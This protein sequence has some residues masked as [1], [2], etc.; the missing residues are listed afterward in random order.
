MTDDQDITYIRG[1]DLSIPCTVTLDDSRT[2]DGDETW[3][4]QLKRDVES[5]TLLSKTDSAGITVDGST[6]QP[7]IVIANSDFTTLQFPPSVTD[8]IYL[9]E[10]QMTKS[11]NHSMPVLAVHGLRVSVDKLLSEFS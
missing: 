8:Q 2:L 4:W 10:L 7:T 6:N 1:D 11:A 9:H 3:A 5:P